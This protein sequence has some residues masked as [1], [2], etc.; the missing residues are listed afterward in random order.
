M[1]QRVIEDVQRPLVVAHLDLEARAG[2]PIGHRHDN[3]VVARA[4]E[5][6][7]VDPVDGAAIELVE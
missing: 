2:A 6:R 5:K 1:R 3:A 4:P 7:E